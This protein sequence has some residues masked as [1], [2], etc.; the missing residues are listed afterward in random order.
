[1]SD[2]MSKLEA[3]VDTLSV[4][5]KFEKKWAN[6]ALRDHAC[7]RSHSMDERV[8]LLEKQVADLTA[9]IEALVG[10]RYE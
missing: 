6:E 2:Q 8:R 1:M 3:E 7:H 4:I 9:I 5:I 10:R